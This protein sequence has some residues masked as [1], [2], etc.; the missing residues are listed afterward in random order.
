L[1]FPANGTVGAR[2]RCVPLIQESSFRQAGR[3]FN[4][5]EARP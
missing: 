4:S 1:V 2:D 3:L 5:G